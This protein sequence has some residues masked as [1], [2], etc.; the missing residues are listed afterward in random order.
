LKNSARGHVAVWNLLWHS[1][2]FVRLV[3]QLSTLARSFFCILPLAKAAGTSGFICQDR[4]ACFLPQRGPLKVCDTGTLAH[5]S[6]I[7]ASAKHEWHCHEWHH[8]F[9]RNLGLACCGN[10]ATPFAISDI[11]HTDAL[12]D[13][14]RATFAAAVR[15]KT[16][17]RGGKREGV[18]CCWPELTFRN[19][20][21]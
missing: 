9:Y 5:S 21:H 2:S 19:I 18:F 16:R 12:S 15:S 8:F 20:S 17:T 14:D 11:P 6:G 3:C 4:F 1:Q 7:L 10:A 13:A